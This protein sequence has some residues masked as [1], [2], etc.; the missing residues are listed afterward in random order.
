MNRTNVTLKI[1]LETIGIS[2]VPIDIYIRENKNRNHPKKWFLGVFSNANDEIHQ[3]NT[4][5]KS[6]PKGLITIEVE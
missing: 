3:A 1:K 4:I 2:G 5:K 6:L